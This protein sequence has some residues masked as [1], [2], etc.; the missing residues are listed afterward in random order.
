MAKPYILKKGESLATVAERTLG[1]PKRAAELA[2]YNGLLD[3]KR[4]VAGQ[5]V[6]IPSARELKPARAAAPAARE[7]PAS[8]AAPHGLQAIIDTFGNIWD[9]VADGDRP[10]PQWET[11]FMVSAKMPFA[12]PLDWAPQQSTSSIRCHKLI[13]PL[14][15]TVFADI[16]AK[17]LQRSVKTYG[18]GYNWRM[19]RGQ[20]KPSTH[21]WGIAIDLNART[22]AMGT[23]GDMDP[24]LVALFE[25]Y[26][27]TWG[28]RWPGTNKDPMHFQ[29]CSGY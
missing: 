26:G 4:V 18:G 25:G 13:A 14:L 2:S 17:G 16:I 22:N 27:F 23:A 7:A 10:D 1:V 8:P 24:A 28:G 21:S 9:Y 12:M 3:A 19:K 6:H 11:Q 15:Q 5:A 20:A 29:Y